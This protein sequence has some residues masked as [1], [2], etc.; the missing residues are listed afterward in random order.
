[1][2]THVLFVIVI[3]PI[4]GVIIAAVTFELDLIPLLFPLASGFALIGPFAAIGLYELSRRR[5][6]GSIRVGPMPT[7]R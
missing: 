6:P 1:M 5:K 7:S 2:P 3:Y 4:S